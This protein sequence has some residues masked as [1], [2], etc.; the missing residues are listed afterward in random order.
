MTRIHIDIKGTILFYSNPAG[1]VRIMK[2][3][4][5][6]IFEKDELIDFLSECN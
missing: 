1:Y 3:L 5:D 4:V 6:P 2:A